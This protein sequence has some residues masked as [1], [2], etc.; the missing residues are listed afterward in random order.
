MEVPVLEFLQPYV[1]T[2]EPVISPVVCV[3]GGDNT[4]D[5]NEIQTRQQQYPSCWIV[6]LKY[7]SAINWYA[8]VFVFNKQQG[9][10]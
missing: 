6:R 4:L 5:I 1:K 7:E 10:Y 9:R 8:V 2:L 3:K